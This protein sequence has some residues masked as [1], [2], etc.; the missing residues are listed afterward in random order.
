[1]EPAAGPWLTSIRRSIRVMTG[2]V[3]TVCVGARE[4]VQPGSLVFVVQVLA[5][6][7]LAVRQNSRSYL[8]C[9]LP[10][11]GSVCPGTEAPEGLFLRQT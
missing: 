4:V 5:P 6:R 9:S 2:P 7:R 10:M 11:T 8:G 1:M 3:D